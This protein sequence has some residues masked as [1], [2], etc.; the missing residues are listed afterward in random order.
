MSAQSDIFYF[1]L[2]GGPNTV[3]QFS[4]TDYRSAKITVQASSNAEHQLSEVY[5]MHDNDLVYIREVN[6]IYTIDP[7]VDFTATIDSNNVYLKANTTLPNTD[8]VIYATLFDNPVTASNKNIDLEKIVAMAA[9]M[10]SLYPDDKTNYANALT[11]SLDKEREIT[12]LNVRVNTAIAY[13]QTAEF[14]GLTSTQQADYINNL[15]NNINN[16][17]DSL[18]QAVASDVE[19]F[20][21]LNRKIDSMTLVANMDANYKNPSAKPILDKVLTQEAK[22]V[23]SAN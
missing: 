21:E 17:S 20:N 1:A 11:S 18:D 23:F 12:E 6:F 16:I 10:A 14:L 3:A 19:T 8:L 7:F 5:L 2:N 9:G 4:K 13:M 22:T 15:A